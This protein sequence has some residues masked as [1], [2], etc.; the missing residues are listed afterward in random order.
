MPESPWCSPNNPIVIDN[1]C[2]KHCSHCH[3][4]PS[5]N[6]FRWQGQINFALTEI[7]IKIK[8]YK[9]WE[10]QR[11]DR[12]T[13]FLFVY[14]GEANNLQINWLR[15]WWWNYKLKLFQ[16]SD[17]PNR[18][19]VLDLGEKNG[20]KSH[21]LEPSTL[22][23]IPHSVPFP[24]LQGTETENLESN[25]KLAFHGKGQGVLEIL[26]NSL[27]FISPRRDGL[28]SSVLTSFPM[29]RPSLLGGQR[30]NK[31]NSQPDFISLSSEL[32]W[33]NLTPRL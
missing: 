1:L 28:E 26:R 24:K 20:L 32:F 17:T 27:N 11:E 23:C 6:L 3:H 33:L 16:N 30:Y 14:K 12:E 7:S 9:H 10:Y 13:F 19:A 15:F 21:S 5:I 4:L 31:G 29:L 18:A 22:L 25:T 2:A 8:E